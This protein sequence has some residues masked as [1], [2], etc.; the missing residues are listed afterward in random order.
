MNSWIVKW[1]PALLRMELDRWLWRDQD[2]VSVKKVWEVL[3]TY[4]Y[5]PRLRDA[6]V[7]LEAIREGLRSRDYFAYATALPM[8][9]GIWA[10]NSARLAVARC[11]LM[12]PVS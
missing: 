11:I 5:M 8:T 2:H 10:C 9:G 7:L 4:N 12:R 1:S 6:D 3:C